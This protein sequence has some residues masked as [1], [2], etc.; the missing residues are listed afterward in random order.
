MKQTSLTL[1]PLA[2]NLQAAIPVAKKCL[3]FY[4]LMSVYDN[5]R[6]HAKYGS[7]QIVIEELCLHVGLLRTWHTYKI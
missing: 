2:M 4:L 6:M 7:N 1:Q 5:A 3:V